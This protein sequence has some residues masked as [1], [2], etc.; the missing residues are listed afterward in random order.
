MNLDKLTTR[1]VPKSAPDG[2]TR[3]FTGGGS[4][5]LVRSWINPRFD[6]VQ[7]GNCTRLVPANS[8]HTVADVREVLA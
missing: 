3:Y 1:P 4:K 6:A 5:V 7:D 8:I 2:T